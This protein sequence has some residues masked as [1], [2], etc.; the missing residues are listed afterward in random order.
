MAGLGCALGLPIAAVV[1]LA[2]ELEPL[3]LLACVGLGAV[4]AVLMGDCVLGQA[5]CEEEEDSAG[6]GGGGGGV[7]RRRPRGLLAALLRTWAEL[8]RLEAV[9]PRLGFF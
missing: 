1:L 6:G 8:W 2:E 9:A 7:V 5:L 3:L 4:G